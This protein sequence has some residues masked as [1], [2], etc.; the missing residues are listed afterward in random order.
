MS[1]ALATK[2][3]TEL[4]QHTADDALAAFASFL[5][6]DVANGDAMPDTVRSYQTQ[7]RGWVT[8]CA[9]RNINAAL[10]TVNDIKVFRAHLV[11]SGA[12]PATIAHKLAVVRRFY[13]AAQAN[14]LRADN[15]ATGVRAPKSRKAADDFAV[16]AEVDL[17]LVFRAIPKNGTVKALRDRAM[18][19][20][21]ALHGWRTVEIHRA[22][23]EDV[24]LH[25]DHARVLVRGKGHDRTMFLRADVHAAVAEYL[26]ARGEVSQDAEG[27]PLFTA[28]GNRAGGKRISRRGI[29]Q[30]ADR[31]LAEADVKR[32]GV[33][34]HALRHTAATLAYA[35]TRDLRAVQDMLGH[36]DP[37][38]TSR[39]AHLVNKVDSPANAIAL[40]L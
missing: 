12:A 6:L 4:P 8:W 5:R 19:A 9:D 11:E 40:K 21:M 22:N 17:A 35:G 36:T 16:L 15:P 23:V 30:V 33:S 34:G 10:A 28:V 26:A 29:R 31:Y 13:G 25:G 18:V 7:I 32:A 20:L 24:E 39:Y 27:T 1:T 14:G 2:T 38:T 3:D 37:R